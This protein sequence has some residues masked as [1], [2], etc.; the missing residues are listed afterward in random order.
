MLSLESQIHWLTE[1]NT[2]LI[3]TARELPD[4]QLRQE[5]NRADNNSGASL[6]MMTASGAAECSAELDDLR[7][8]S[9][10]LEQ[11]CK[12]QMV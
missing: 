6:L 5:D 12:W 11:V 7:E 3:K 1:Q 8:K 4:Q 10:S 2:H 9:A